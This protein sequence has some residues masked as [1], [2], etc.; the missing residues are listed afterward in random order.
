VL[1]CPARSSREQKTGISACSAFRG[2]GV[3][4]L[5]GAAMVIAGVWLVTFR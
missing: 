5:A 4:K 3:G 2:P 1:Q